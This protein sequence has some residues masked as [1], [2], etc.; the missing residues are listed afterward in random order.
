MPHK[1]NDLTELR[2]LLAQKQVE[3]T[4]IAIARKREAGQHQCKGAH[5]VTCTVMISLE[6]VRCVKC[7]VEAKK[8]VCGNCPA[9]FMPERPTHKWCPGCEEQKRAE[10]A[11]EEAERAKAEAADKAEAAAILAEIRYLDRLE[12]HGEP[13]STEGCTNLHLRSPNFTGQRS[14]CPACRDAHKA[15]CAERDAKRLEAATKAVLPVAK[16]SPLGPKTAEGKAAKKAANELRKKRQSDRIAMLPMLPS[17][18]KR[19]ETP[20]NPHMGKK[21]G[22]K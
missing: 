22:K 19:G 5:G 3:V 21:K 10:R 4:D 13:C 15:R 11:A 18:G 20:F 7:N 8:R 16:P 6:L 9:L 1:T 2:A 14:F 17:V 12:K